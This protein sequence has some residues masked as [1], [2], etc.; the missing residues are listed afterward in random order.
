M[1]LFL[2]YLP[3]IYFGLKDRRFYLHGGA[4][5]FLIMAGRKAGFDSLEFL[6]YVLNGVVFAYVFTH[7][8]K[9]KYTLFYILLFSLLTELAF[10]LICEYVPVYRTAYRGLIAA[11]TALLTKQL[12]MAQPTALYDSLQWNVLLPLSEIIKNV[13]TTLVLTL[14]FYRV[15]VRE[16]PRISDF[17]LPDWFIW[18]LAGGLLLTIYKVIGVAG[19]Y[20]LMAAGIFYALAGIAI[21]RLFFERMGSSR[22]GETL[23]Y[24]VQP[25]LLFLP[26]LSIG[27]METWWDFRK[28]IM[29]LEVAGKKKDDKKDI[30]N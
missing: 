25:G 24:L 22:I 20:I 17:A 12:G 14:L 18:V 11:A 28:R 8:F 23:F 26:V 3:L 2:I 15:T 4:A 1:P 5:V 9:R 13:L 21:I 16:K 10:M 19:S 29:A 27:V 7:L 6:S 30:E